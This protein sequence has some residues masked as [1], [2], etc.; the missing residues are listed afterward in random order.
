MEVLAALHSQP[1]PA[2]RSV[3]VVS[4]AGGLGIL[5]ADA[6]VR[7]G[8]AVPELSGRTMDALRDLLPDTASAHNPVDTTAVVDEQT[9]ARCLDLVGADPAVHA[10]IA[11]TV[12]TAAGDPEGGVH[13]T[14]SGKPVLA[15]LAGQAESVVLP[16][17]GVPRYVD[18]ARAAAVLARL[19]ER[20]QWLARPRSDDPDLAGIDLDAAREVVTDHLAVEPEGGWLDPDRVV[21]LLRAF[22]LPVL[23]GVL[24]TT[25]QGAVVAQR[26]YDCPVAL[27]A[28]A[29]GLLHKSKGGGVVLGL[30]SG[31]AVIEAFERFRQRFGGDLRGA[32]VQ[33]MAAGG[34]ELLVG[35]VTD[36]LFGPLVVTGL[37]GVDTDVI[38]DRACALAPLST[39]DAQELVRD[40]H[41]SERVF[42]DVDDRPVRDVLMRVARLAELVPEIAELDLNPLVVSARQCLVV[43]ARVRV[44]PVQP[45]DPFLRRLRV[46]GTEVGHAA[47]HD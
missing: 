41:A 36:P 14:Q 17:D 29:G 4:N 15:V 26:T 42:A 16:A 18:P 38:D 46:G 3:A 7:N 9:F 32:F 30:D 13:R 23:G 35:V 20:A 12:P 33:P 27:K 6:C 28:V 1:L 25:A 40:F 39:T 37:G 8:L 31:E 47:D 21:A 45:V 5:A 44:H 43:D 10:V 34:R 19:V 24:A 11:V 2:G 22:G